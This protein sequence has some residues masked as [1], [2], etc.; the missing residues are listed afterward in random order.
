MRRR[1][2]LRDYAIALFCSDTM[3]RIGVVT[4]VLLVALLFGVYAGYAAT[5]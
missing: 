1:P 5:H 3:F 4:A 2:T